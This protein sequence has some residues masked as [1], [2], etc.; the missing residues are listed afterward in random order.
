[1]VQ[2]P[3]REGGQ[4]HPA[5]SQADRRGSYAG[6]MAGRGDAG[7]GEELRSAL[8]WPTGK[9]AVSIASNR[10]ARSGGGWSNKEQRQADRKS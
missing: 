7:T 1:M 9:R 6:R 8:R 4:D 10:A 5:R 3:G 2:T